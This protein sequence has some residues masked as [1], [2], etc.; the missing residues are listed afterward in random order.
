VIE[1]EF[2]KNKW[3]NKNR[4]TKHKPGVNIIVVNDNYTHTNPELSNKP[5]PSENGG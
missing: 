1:I 5:L 3:R 2:D 4:C